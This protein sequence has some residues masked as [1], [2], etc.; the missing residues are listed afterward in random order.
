MKGPVAAPRLRLLTV[1]A[2][3]AAATRAS[4]EVRLEN[5][6]LRPASSGQASAMV[7]VDI[8]ST[9]PLRLVAASSPVAKRAELVLVETPGPDAA[10][11]VV[12]EILVAANEPR[13]LAYLGSHV[14]LVLISQDVAPGSRIPLE[15]VFI[16]AAGARR[17]VVTDAQVRGLMPR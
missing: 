6:W 7:Y 2:A 13:R 3:L 17:S 4:A 5:A 15:L 14:R 9:E 8:V 10:Q 16:D 12:G 1:A 11:S